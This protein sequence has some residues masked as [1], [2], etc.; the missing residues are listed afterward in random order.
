MMVSVRKS[1]SI[2]RVLN[3]TDVTSAKNIHYMMDVR[4]NERYCFL[5]KCCTE[6]L[7]KPV[8]PLPEQ[9]FHKFPSGAC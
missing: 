7:I 2:R 5:E 4:F 3:L 8:S 6:R 1:R 9:S